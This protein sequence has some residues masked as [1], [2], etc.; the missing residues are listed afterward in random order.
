[1]HIHAI[2]QTKYNRETVFQKAEST[3]TLKSFLLE[4]K[5]HVNIEREF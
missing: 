5:K 2:P 4:L 3:S 1:M